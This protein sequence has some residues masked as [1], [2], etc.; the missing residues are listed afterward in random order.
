VNE[1]AVLVHA[2]DSQAIASHSSTVFQRVGI[3]AEVADAFHFTARLAQ[4]ETDYRNGSHAAIHEEDLVRANNNLVSTLGAPEWAQTNQQEV[5]KLRMEFM[6]RYPQL[7][8]NQAPA[9]ENGH[10]QAL[11]KNISPIE[12]TFLATSLIYQK[13]YAPDYQL[14][15]KEK[16]AGG[17]AA[18]SPAIFLQRTQAL[19]DILHGNAQNLS[20]FDL[21]HAADGRFSDLGISSSLRPEFASLQTAT[22]Q[23][24][25]KEGR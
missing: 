20:I 22:A 18:L 6:A 19:L 21:T 14:T 17:K 25:G 2:G 9:D 7:L 5:R 3:P 12:A 24:S 4:A 23:T 16:A 11:S 1:Q 13:L 8:A 15:A 10:F